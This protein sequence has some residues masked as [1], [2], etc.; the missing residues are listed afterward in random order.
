MQTA[1]ELAEGDEAQTMVAIQLISWIAAS[2]A[3]DINDDSDAIIELITQGLQSEDEPIAK[4]ASSLLEEIA[5]KAPTA[6]SPHMKTN[7]IAKAA[8]QHLQFRTQSITRSSDHI[9]AFS[10]F[11]FY[12]CS[13]GIT[14]V[15]AQLSL[16]AA[17]ALSSTDFEIARIGGEQCSF[18]ASILAQNTDSIEELTCMNQRKARII[19]S[20][21]PQ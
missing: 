8:F 18:F 1:S 13:S 3:D 2:C 9:V 10:K 20:R 11:M 19:L 6:V 7:S 21:L 12:A 5:A 17:I 4:A 14:G 15:D 16:V